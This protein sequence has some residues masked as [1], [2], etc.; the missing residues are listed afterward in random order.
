MIDLK[1]Q[2]HQAVDFYKELKGIHPNTL[3]VGAEIYDAITETY[4]PE[5]LLHVEGEMILL[6]G[7]KIIIDTNTKN[8]FRLDPANTAWK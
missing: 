4:A 8:K 1:T 5:G 2:I 6:Y 3:F 7:M